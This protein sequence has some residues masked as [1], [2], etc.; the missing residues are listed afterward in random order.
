MQP[1]S[2]SLS[3]RRGS[4]RGLHIDV[5][6]PPA[7]TAVSLPPPG[8]S[9]LEKLEAGV[10]VSIAELDFS[11]SDVDGSIIGRV[12]EVVKGGRCPRFTRIALNIGHIGGTVSGPSTTGHSFLADLC[13]AAATHGAP[14]HL[15]IELCMSP[16]CLASIH[17][18]SNLLKS[19][20]AP[21]NLCIDL[22]WTRLDEMMFQELWWGVTSKGC[23]ED[24]EL[25]LN[26][27]QLSE[28][29]DGFGWKGRTQRGFRLGLRE[30]ALG[31]V[32]CAALCEAL[33]HGGALSRCA[34][35][36]V[37]ANELSPQDVFS[38]CSALTSGHTPQ[39]FVLG[40]GENPIC[41]IA[42]GHLKT[43][44]REAPINFTLDL[45][46]SHLSEGAWKVIAS[47]IQKNSAV[48]LKIILREA[49][50]TRTTLSYFCDAIESGAPEGMTLGLQ[51][52]NL[53][54]GCIEVL[55]TTLASGRCPRGLD[56]SIAQNRISP[57]GLSLLSKTLRSASLPTELTLNLSA[58]ELS[59]SEFCHLFASIGADPVVCPPLS[60]S[61]HGGSFGVEVMK[62]VCSCLARK[63][64]PQ[65][66]CL[67]FAGS[68]VDED[69][70]ALLG[71][72]LCSGI[73]P[74]YLT[75][76]LSS[77]DG[78][79]TLLHNTAAIPALIPQH[80]TLNLSHCI[81]C[82]QAVSALVSIITDL[83]GPGCLKIVLFDAILDI[84]E[85]CSAVEKSVLPNLSLS[86]NVVEGQKIEE[87]MSNVSVPEGLQVAVCWDGVI[88]GGG[89]L[90][91]S[92]QSVASS[93]LSPGQLLSSF[94]RRFLDADLPLSSPSSSRPSPK[95]TQ[96]PTSFAQCTTDTI[97]DNI[98]THR[99]MTPFRRSICI[100][101][102]QRNKSSI[103]DVT[104]ILET[105]ISKVEGLIEALGVCSERGTWE[106]CG[107]GYI[108][109]VNKAYECWMNA[110]GGCVVGDVAVEERDM[111][112]REYIGTVRRAVHFADT[113]ANTER[114]LTKMLRGIEAFCDDGG[115]H[116][117]TTTH[118]AYLLAKRCANHLQSSAESCASALNLVEEHREAFLKALQNFAKDP[119]E[120]GLGA[121]EYRH[122]M[123]SG[124]LRRWRYT[125]REALKGLP[126]ELPEL[127][128][129]MKGELKEL[130]VLAEARRG[131]ISILE[132]EDVRVDPF[133]LQNSLQTTIT[134]YETAEEAFEDA[135][136]LLR[137][138]QRRGSVDTTEL[139]ALEANAERNRNSLHSALHDLSV[140]EQNTATAVI[141]YYPELA[142]KTVRHWDG[143]L[144]KRTLHYYSDRVDGGDVVTAKRPDGLKCVLTRYAGNES[145]TAQVYRETQC[146]RRVVHRNVMAVEAV[147]VD[148]G[149]WWVETAFH[150]GSLATGGDLRHLFLQVALG[151]EALHDAGV[152]HANLT[153]QSVLLV[154][155]VARI[156]NFTY[157][158][159][160]CT[161]LP[162]SVYSAPELADGVCT[163]G[164]DIYSFGV[165]LKEACGDAPE[166]L[167]FALLG[168]PE[169]RPSASQIS[170]HE[171]FVQQQL[172]PSLA[173]PA[174]WAGQDP[175]GVMVEVT[176]GMKE[177]MQ[178]LISRTLIQ[179]Q[180]GKGRN[181]STHGEG[182]SGL[183]VR[184]VRRVEHVDLWA[185]YQ[186]QRAQLQARGS[187]D[188]VTPISMDG[189]L[190]SEVL[191][192]EV[193]E[194][195]VFHGTQKAYIT[196]IAAQGMDE[197]V[198]TWGLYGAG[199]YFAE[200]SSK[201]DEY[202]VPDEEGNCYLLVCRVLLGKVCHR[203]SPLE[204]QKRT[205]RR[206]PCIQGHVDCKI[207]DM[208]DSVVAEHK[209][210]P[211]EFVLFDRSRVYPEYVVTVRRV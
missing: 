82:P 131:F 5:A 171:Y 186:L 169:N 178:T 16:L 65:H 37:A 74:A 84:N 147:F 20:R 81:L 97:I 109:K 158:T 119:I 103:I 35:I 52:V 200:N 191:L 72:Q 17:C 45:T 68:E 24:L 211:R 63:Y 39:N 117:T 73:C 163:S 9:T 198:C 70:L 203:T 148:D 197:R 144:F 209:A 205:V 167:F 102:E 157:S 98:P 114:L 129:R 161:L 51:N 185:A 126:G 40:I 75:L 143:I 32:H 159:T 80:L 15:R 108:E 57:R 182:Y 85:V 134:H 33:S 138:A 13:S 23:P 36:D 94:S 88:G 154:D 92:P 44:L 66:F 189:S 106:G 208:A 61:F 58:S 25:I 22:S 59:Q 47:G 132:A 28:C 111:S 180:L 105:R 160:D 121:L 194:V 181:S 177:T 31:G 165:M 172:H 29:L 6:V 100:L 10:G 174:F 190:S 3:L 127:A 199:L 128:E 136:F 122:C 206:P 43:L 90:P 14:R 86:F 130:A 166:E 173:P 93:T 170:R 78:V 83:E 195:H 202:M 26:W 110:K 7:P 125:E 41:E 179:S 146:M 116:N 113:A 89:D 2:E 27:C 79:S 76:D 156:A 118:P 187:V 69:G 192:S 123:L 71:D 153:P 112:R 207:H 201:A 95:K 155:G 107:G 21:K 60:L 149:V 30:N 96:I 120:G 210:N 91:A 140:C 184:C 67:S 55:C 62:E 42:A 133:S 168:A 204:G 77:V 46:A 34:G 150:E 141:Q 64:C 193:N 188:S 135:E 162:R 12:C 99:G 183:Q 151:L 11:E 145:G 53:S 115:A 38:L 142:E 48:G 19:G 18:L 1:P 104:S 137:R 4:E 175:R 176:E 101:G 8:L 124:A 54:E 87:M 49:N 139:R 196:T 50:L 152:V 56:V 164:V